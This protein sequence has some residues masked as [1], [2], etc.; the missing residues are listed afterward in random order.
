MYKQA[1]R[2]YRAL[3][4]GE[5]I[6]PWRTDREQMRQ[7]LIDRGLG[8]YDEWGRFFTT[9]PGDIDRRFVIQSVGA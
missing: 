5:P 3:S 8:G 2:Q 4:F 9:V 1:V 7:D 6:G